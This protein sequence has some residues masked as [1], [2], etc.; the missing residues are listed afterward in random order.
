MNL[1]VAVHFVFIDGCP[2]DVSRFWMQRGAAVLNGL[3]I[4]G[5]DSDPITVHVASDKAPPLPTSPLPI[6]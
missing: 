6:V 2:F 5:V 1:V 3:V 4:H